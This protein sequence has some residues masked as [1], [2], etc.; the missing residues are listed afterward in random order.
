[1]C[2]LSNRNIPIYI[3]KKSWKKSDKEF[4]KI[5]GCISKKDIFYLKLDMYIKKFKL[6]FSENQQSLKKIEICEV[7]REIENAGI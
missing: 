2:R 3:W 1:M 5:Q 7:M 4:K 6:E